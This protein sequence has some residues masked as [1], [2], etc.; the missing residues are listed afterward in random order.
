[1]TL[2]THRKSLCLNT[3]DVSLQIIFPSDACLLL[4]ELERG[5]VQ[6]VETGIQRHIGGKSH[7]VPNAWHRKGTQICHLNTIR[8]SGHVN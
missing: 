8:P 3:E 2:L 4:E 6:L 5:G 7:V 1:M